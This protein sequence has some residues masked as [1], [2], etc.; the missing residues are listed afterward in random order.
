MGYIC[1]NVVR[2]KAEDSVV[3]VPGDEKRIRRKKME[4]W[5]KV[6]SDDERR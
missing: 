4:E 1:T 6:D 2:I 5:S 3:K